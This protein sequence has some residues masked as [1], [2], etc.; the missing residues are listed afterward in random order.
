MPLRNLRKL[1]TNPKQKGTSSDLD[2]DCEKTSDSCGDSKNVG[3]QLP[4][5][6]VWP[7]QDSPRKPEKEGQH[8]IFSCDDVSSTMQNDSGIDSV[9]VIKYFNFTDERGNEK[10]QAYVEENIGMRIIQTHR[11]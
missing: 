7:S 10:P 2:I 6:Q 3:P 4:L 8:F 5:L 1:W 9:Q 11:L